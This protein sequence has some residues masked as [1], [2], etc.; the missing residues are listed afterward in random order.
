MMHSES[1]DTLGIEMRHER[2]HDMTSVAHTF[3]AGADPSKTSQ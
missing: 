2:T 3:S 1:S